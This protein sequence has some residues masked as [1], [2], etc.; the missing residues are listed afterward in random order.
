[1]NDALAGEIV[2]LFARNLYATGVHLRVLINSC[3]RMHIE[4]KMTEPD[5][6][7]PVY[8]LKLQDF[9]AELDVNFFPEFFRKNIPR[10]SA[11]HGRI[12]TPL[13]LKGYNTS[14]NR[15]VVRFICLRVDGG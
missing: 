6:P 10:T 15:A 5:L 14:Y 9:D 3:S 11:I 4:S 7:R 12:Q 2:S 13:T 8:T 1:M